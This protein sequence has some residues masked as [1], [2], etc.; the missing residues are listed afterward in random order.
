MR[1][2]ILAVPAK[3]AEVTNIDIKAAIAGVELIDE[4]QRGRGALRSSDQRNWMFETRT[5][6]R[7]SWG[8]NRTPSPHLIWLRSPRR[9]L[10][11][12]RSQLRSVTSCNCRYSCRLFRPLI[13]LVLLASFLALGELIDVSTKEI[14]RL[15]D[16]VQIK[17]TSFRRPRSTM[18]GDGRTFQPPTQK[19]SD[20]LWR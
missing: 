20:T 10:F 15:F 16:L 9:H 19:L 17:V 7:R 8:P 14:I 2:F 4:W 12:K 18:F 13:R 5:S 3:V 1:L 11:T 6:Q